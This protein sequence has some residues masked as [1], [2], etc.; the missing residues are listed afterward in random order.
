MVIIPGYKSRCI[1]SSNNGLS[2]I[3]D[4]FFNLLLSIMAR[5]SESMIFCF[6]D[7]IDN[8]SKPGFG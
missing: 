4:G 1:W 8:F 5:C 6:G 2:R 3:K 7:A